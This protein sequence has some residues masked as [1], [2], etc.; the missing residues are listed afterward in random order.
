MSERRVI[1]FRAWS[2]K[3]MYQVDALSVVIDD[4]DNGSFALTSVETQFGEIMDEF[5]DH[6][7]MQFTGLHDKNGKE[8]YEGDIV[9][10]RTNA[11]VAV[12]W[13]DDAAGWKPWSQYNETVP[14]PG[15]RP[16]DIEVIGNIYENP[17]LM[18]GKS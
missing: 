8:I 3:H 7:L 10:V 14:S 12:E 17:E 4:R 2:G 15:E 9:D 18:E 5:P 13:D 6:V 11:P 1:K 16:E